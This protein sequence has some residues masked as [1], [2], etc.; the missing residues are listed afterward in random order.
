MAVRNLESYQRHVQKRLRALRIVF[1]RAAIGDFS[2]NVALYREEDDFSEL[3]V[4]VQV[5]LEVIREQLKELKGLNRDMRD[6][7]SALARANMIIAQE[8]AQAET[9]LT[10][11]GEGVVAADEKGKIL[12]VN[13]AAIHMLRATRRQLVG[14]SVYTVL[15][16]KDTHEVLVPKS[17]CPV[18]RSRKQKTVIRTSALSFVRKD[19]SLL[20]VALTAAPVQMNDV[21]YGTIEVFRDITRERDIDRAKSEFVS[22]ASHQLRTPLT[23]VKWSVQALLSS[24]LG[25]LNNRQR[26]YS[27]RILS[28]NVR[29]IRLVEALLNVSRIELGT[30]VTSRK[31]VDA[32]HAVE[33]VIEE[34]SVQAKANSVR[35]TATCERQCPKVRVD[36]K[37]LPIAFHNIISNAI[38]YSKRGGKIRITIAPEDGTV[39]FAFADHGIGIPEDQQ[40]RIFTKLFRAK[41]AI[42]VVQDGTGLGL[43][44]AK[45]IIEELG[46]SIAFTSQENAG[47][48]FTVHLPIAKV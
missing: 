21:Q 27:E 33:D 4:G 5:M 18:T 2:K 45:A 14:K 47:T 13:A 23:T 42:N 6:K 26:R 10:G 15:R 8:K 38:K 46:G 34:L 29:M 43:Y 9:L 31:P 25:P 48:T 37:V 20:P 17:R 41:N 24:S 16:L 28:A 44:T 36:P 1:A 11:I 32:L 40:D 3:Y 19:G 39:R 22:L 35:I 12:L 30:L 7:L